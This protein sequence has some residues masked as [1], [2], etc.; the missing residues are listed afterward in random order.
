[1]KKTIASFAA[2]LAAVGFAGAAQAQSVVPLAI[3]ARAS[4]AVPTGD[5]GDTGGGIGTGYG[6]GVNGELK[7]NPLFGVYGGYSWTGYDFEEGDDRVEQQGVDAGV[8]VGL[9]LLPLNPYARAGIV[10]HKL[11]D[12]IAENERKLGYELGAGLGFPLG[13]VISVTP[14]VSYT[15]INDAL[16]DNDHLSAVRFGVGLRAAL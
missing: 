10:Y 15:R 2:A 3:E 1:M 6:F 7:L 16:G 14:E 13:R 5:F 11:D 12:G 9:G 8:R 4:A